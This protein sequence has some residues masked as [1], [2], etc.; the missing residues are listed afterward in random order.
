MRVSGFLAGLV[1]V[2]EPSEGGLARPSLGAGEP[3]SSDR[4]FAGDE[5]GLEKSA[6]FGGVG[7]DCPAFRVGLFCEAD[8]VE[9][10]DHG[11]DSGDSLAFV[12][13]VDW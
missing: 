13:C 9:M 6:T 12:G 11:L 5:L 2:W 7:V 1:I 3:Y 4:G 10:I 8:E